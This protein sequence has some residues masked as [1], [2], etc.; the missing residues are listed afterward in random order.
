MATPKSAVIRTEGLVGRERLR[1]ALELLRDAGSRGITRAQLCHGLGDASLRSVDRAIALLEEQGAKL[2]RTRAGSPKIL[3]F[4]LTK[5][6]TWDEHVSSEARLALRLAALSL[7]QCG[8][9][10]WQ[11]KL[12][13]IEELASGRMS[14]RDRKLFEQLQRAVRV[15]GGVEDPIESSE[16]LEPILRALEDSREIEV[17]YQSAGSKSHDLKNMIPY[18]LTHDLYSGGAFLLVWDPVRRKPLHLRLN[19]ISKVKVLNRPGVITSVET[20]ERAARYQIGGWMSDQEPFEVEVR[21]TGAHWVQSFKEAPPALP[22]FQS[23]PAKDG[24]S[25]IVKFKAN[26]ENGASRWILQFGA[27]AEVFSPEQLRKNVASQLAEA[28]GRYTGPT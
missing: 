1:E 11:D 12:E 23:I 17:E 10:L 19:R 3:H 20:L 15:H 8:T 14:S 7:S 22:E 9:Q 24:K 6:P 28:L 16:I 2:E 26:H 25:M 5:G 4:R 27:A 18:A 13:T 21:I